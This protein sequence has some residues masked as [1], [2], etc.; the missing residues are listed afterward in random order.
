[1]SVDFIIIVRKRGFSMSDSNTKYEELQD[2][3]YTG[4]VRP[5]KE[6]KKQSIRISK[7]FSR[8][9]YDVVSDRVRKC[10]DYLEFKRF[11]DGSL[12]LFHA[13]FC[14][15]RLCPMC[16]WRRSLLV[17]HQMKECVDYLYKDFD[18]LFLT[19]TVKNCDFCLLDS[20]LD[21]MKASLNRLFRRKDIKKVVKGLFYSFE[22]TLNRNNITW[23]PHIHI[24][25][26]VNKSYFKK[27]YIRQDL[28]SKYWMESCC[29]DYIPVVH[30]EKFKGEIG[31]AV[32]EAA[33]YTLKSDTVLCDDDIIQ[34]MIT[35]ILYSSMKNKRFI[36]YR[37]VFKEARKIL[38]LKDIEDSSF[39]NIDNTV[40]DKEY[41]LE[42]YFFQSGYNDG[43]YIRIK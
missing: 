23:H 20:Y 22:I 15:N 34:D 31:K 9:G 2:V 33:K 40:S 12:K 39:V 8:I 42:K 4:K 17:Y 38:G 37:G 32:A 21:D 24:C 16:N 19:L 28:W 41:V 1:M 36:S 30:V 7:S 35:D 26:A 43:T 5:W 18:F 3:S 25:I 6:K 27:G 11:D 13:F 29:I 10:G 14:K